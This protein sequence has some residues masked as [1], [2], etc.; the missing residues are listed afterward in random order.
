[1][2]RDG[3]PVD[4]AKVVFYPTNGTRGPTV[5]ATVAEGRY[6]IPA[7]DGLQAG[8]YL[9]AVSLGGPPDRR[10]FMLAPA[11][12]PKPDQPIEFERQITGEDAQIDLE[13]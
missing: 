5:G 9:V 13:L 3:Q 11:G 7:S 4:W 12:L 10:A 8:H 6:R 1:V 2:T